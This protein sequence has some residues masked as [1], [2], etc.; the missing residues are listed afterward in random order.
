MKILAFDPGYEKLGYAL[1]VKKSNPEYITSGL[2]KTIRTKTEGERL[3]DI[4][5][6]VTQIILREQ[7]DQVAIE[8]L[9][10]SKNVRTALGVSQVIG[11]ILLLAAQN[12]LKVLELTPKQIKETITG[13]GAADKKALQKMLWLQIGRQIVVA[14]DDESDAIACG[15]AACLRNSLLMP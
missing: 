4:Y 5:I 2:I 8:K 1:F 14:D 6:A 12:N 3:L 13:Y 10:F 7:P 9:F 11:I 15:L